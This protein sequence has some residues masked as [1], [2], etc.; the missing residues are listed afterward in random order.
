MS[1]ILS[2]IGAKGSFINWADKSEMIPTSTTF[3]RSE[4]GYA[5]L[6]NG[7]DSKI[8]AGALGDLTGDV[9]VVAWI[10]PYSY[11]EGNQGMIIT[12]TKLILQVFNDNKFYAFSDGADVAS[13]TAV[14]ELNKWQQITLTRESDGT[15]AFYHNGVDVTSDAVSATPT[16]GTNTIIGNLTSSNTWDGLIAK[17]EI[18]DKIFTL[19]EIAQEY[20]SFLTSWSLSEELYPRYGSWNKPTDMSRYQGLGLL[21]HYNMIRSTGDAMVDISDSEA[22]GTSN[23]CI[24]TLAG[25]KWDGEDDHLAVNLSLAPAA[26]VKTIA[27][28]IKLDTTSEQIYEGQSND[29][30]ILANAGTLE[31]SDWDNIYING[32]ENSTVYADKWMNVVI[33]SSTVVDNN[34]PSIG[35]NS[36]TFDYGAFE[37]EDFQMWSTE[38][39]AE[40]VAEYS[41]G[42][43]R[44]V[45]AEKLTY[46]PVGSNLPVGW[47]KESGTFSVKEDSTGKYI[48]CDAAGDIKLTGRNLSNAFIKKAEGSD[49]SLSASANGLV[50]NMETEG[51]LRNVIYVNG[52]SIRNFIAE[53]QAIY[54]AFTTKPDIVTAYIWNRFVEDAIR[55][56]EWALLDVFY[57][58]AAHTNADGEALINWFNPGTFDA[59]AYNAPTF[60]ANEGFTGAD[61]KYIDCNWNPS[62]N[63]INYVQNSASMGVYCRTDVDEA[64]NAVGLNATVDAFIRIRSGNQAGFRVNSTGSGTVANLD[65]RGMYVSNRV[66]STHQDLWK[67]KI[68]IS[69][70]L[71][72]STGV[73]NVNVYT[74]ALNNSVVATNFVT[75]QISVAFA[76]AGMTQTNVNNLTNYYNTAMTSLGKNVF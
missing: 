4:K 40:E 2:F 73:P 64:K 29:I 53:Y 47:Q 46:A 42:F 24:D 57:N 72:T 6:F 8:D 23:G 28:R 26:T 21:L 61:T 71:R 39:S 38:W 31:A 56:G 25:L 66:L 49:F 17:A 11:G 50:A 1:K 63:G 7:V 19:E 32:V 27:F 52:Y 44:V 5:G 74:L 35:Y 59:T 12:N 68:R 9:T 60:T 69:N 76:G 16:A 45:L 41:N 36:G 67:N 70:H 58:Y 75:T 20:N 3:F 14:L 13:S 37:M 43:V 30:L 54:D 34:T 22:P 51:K 10:K 15:C 62:T 48:S 33:T 55:T 65:S 18:H